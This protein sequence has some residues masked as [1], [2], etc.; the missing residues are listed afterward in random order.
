MSSFL[1]DLRFA[2]RQLRRAPGF[3]LTVISIL[4]L[5][6]GATAAL[7]GVLRATLLNRLPYPHPGELVTVRDRNLQGFK[8]NGIMTMARVGDLTTMVHD[9]HPLFTGVGYYYASDGQLVLEG[10]DP[11][12]VSGVG[13]SGDF[14][15]TIGAAPLLGRT[16]TT[17]DDVQ[18]APYV[19]VISHGLWQSAFSGDASVLGR[20]V[21][22]GTDH[23]TI[24]GVMPARFD[25]PGGTE[26][27][28][29]GRL[30]RAQFQ[31]YR[32][33][34]SRFLNVIARLHPAETIATATQETALLATQLARAYPA[35]DAI[36]SFDLLESANEPVR[37]RAVAAC[38]C[39]PRLSVWCCWWWRRTLPGCNSPAM[40]CGRPSLGFVRHWGF[41]GAG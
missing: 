2:L 17:A 41:R 30:S 39:C 23:A 32:G 14:F 12:R 37:R 18:N 16:I 7:S 4:A 27:W 22:L 26:V 25:L 6:V 11:L 31:G 3:S 36:W 19:A 9:G 24:I 20:S 35:T 28:Y 8:T 38:C 21:R 13:V 29:P 10:H 1:Q 5:S 40:P 33:D 15:R 34:G